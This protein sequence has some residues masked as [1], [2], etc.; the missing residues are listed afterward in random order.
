MAKKNQKE[1]EKPKVAPSKDLNAIVL[2][3]LSGKSPN[4]PKCDAPPSRH[5][6]R[7]HSVIWHDGDVHC[8]KCGTYVRMYDAG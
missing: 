3:V 5:E 1:T 7:N 6:V 4:C 2:P 8:T